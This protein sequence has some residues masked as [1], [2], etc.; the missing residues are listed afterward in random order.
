MQDNNIEFFQQRIFE[1]LEF[2]T[3]YRNGGR[4]ALSHPTKMKCIPN[5]IIDYATSDRH[6]KTIC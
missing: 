6:V 5:I 1:V 3:E 2:N 4:K